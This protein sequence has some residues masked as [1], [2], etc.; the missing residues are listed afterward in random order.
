LLY[1]QT[2]PTAQ[3]LFLKRNANPRL[4]QLET[5][6]Q[7]IDFADVVDLEDEA[8]DTFA[9]GGPLAAR[10]KE[11]VAKLGSVE[12]VE[13]CPED[14]ARSSNMSEV[15]RVRMN[16]EGRSGSR[17]SSDN[18][19]LDRSSTSLNQPRLDLTTHPSPL[20]TSSKR[21]QESTTEPRKRLQGFQQPPHKELYSQPSTPASGTMNEGSID[22]D[23]PLIVNMASFRQVMGNR[24]ESLARI[25]DRPGIDVERK[26]LALLLDVSGLSRVHLSVPIP[27]F[28]P[29]IC[30]K[31]VLILR[32]VPWFIHV[33]KQQC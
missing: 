19:S 2:C 23:T 5:R 32:H 30:S 16:E 13:K 3:C 27:F 22:L 17:S 31:R 21:T 1:Y 10:L 18:T 11:L 24:L 25:R 6:R 9:P 26:R 12:Q 8:D 15:V 33:R 4:L 14:V 7:S 20:A 29:R 28:E